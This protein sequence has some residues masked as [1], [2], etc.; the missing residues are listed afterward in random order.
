MSTRRSAL[1]HAGSSDRRFAR[2]SCLDGS[3]RSLISGV[4]TAVMSTMARVSVE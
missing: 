4:D 3:Y 1:R 2:A